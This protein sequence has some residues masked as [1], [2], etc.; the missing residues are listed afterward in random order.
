M[1]S[2]PSSID[3]ATLVVID[4]SA[5]INLNASGYA[6][7][8]VKSISGRIVA[9]H[10]VLDELRTGTSCGRQ[11]AHLLEEL[12]SGGFIDLVELGDEAELHFE[13]LV[14]G[15]A[16]ATLDDGEAATISYAISANGIAIVDERKAN[17]IC[18]EQFQALRVGCTVDLFA[19]TQVQQSLG[20][21]VLAE[22]V[23]NAL[24]RGRMRVFS[25][26]LAWV[27]DLI[28]VDRAAA[29]RSLPNSAIPISQKR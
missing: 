10:A 18:A 2:Q 9:V 7:E 4:T 12:V 20:R 29:C 17:R 8:I 3:S 14:N 6:Q 26:D 23:F 15:P 21:E 24:R 25:R 5:V 22:A 28:G 1:G 16:I 11:D 13:K 27:V 19:S